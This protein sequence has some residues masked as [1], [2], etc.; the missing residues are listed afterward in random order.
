MGTSRDLKL[1]KEYLREIIILQMNGDK[2]AHSNSE[3]EYYCTR[4]LES[5]TPDGMKSKKQLRYES[6]MRVFVEQHIQ[7][8][9]GKCIHNPEL[10]SRAYMN[11]TESS[12]IMAHNIGILDAER[13]CSDRLLSGDDLFP[14]AIK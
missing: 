2:R 8:Q 11:V 1:I 10:L 13:V 4:G 5:M 14:A 12:R 6:R 9:H 7:F 3:S